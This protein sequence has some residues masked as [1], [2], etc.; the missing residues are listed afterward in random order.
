MPR[1]YPGTG[2]GARSAAKA[3]NALTPA[4]HY[5][6]ASSMA[7]ERGEVAELVEEVKTA[8]Q[9]RELDLAAAKKA[10]GMR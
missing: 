6:F 2:K 8:V 5:R 4:D 9:K 10:L 1:G 7:V 3:K